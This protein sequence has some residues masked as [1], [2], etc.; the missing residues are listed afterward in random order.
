MPRLADDAARG[1]DLILATAASMFRD[2]GFAATSIRDIAEA[3]G[4]S[5]AALYYHFPSKEAIY[6]SLVQPAFDRIAVHLE[7]PGPLDTVA[8]RR[9]YLRGFIAIIASL[10]PGM[11]EMLTDPGVEP[12]MREQLGTLPLRVARRL[13]ESVE[14]GS[15]T[16]SA[17]VRAAAA[18]AC[19]PAGLAAWAREPESIDEDEVID[20]IAASASAALEGRSRRGAP[21]A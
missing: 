16:A 8:R 20:L 1:R 13:A 6:L 12:G 19:V 7:A 3:L 4:V 9:R 14:S 15:S 10:G 18:M 11:L 2:R 17:R 21:D 5:K